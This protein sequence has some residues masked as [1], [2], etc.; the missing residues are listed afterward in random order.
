MLVGPNRGCDEA[1]LEVKHTERLVEAVARGMRTNHLALIIKQARET[2][3]V[4]FKGMI[5]PIAALSWLVAIEEI[6]E[7]G[8]WFP[9]EDNFRI[10]GFLL[11][12]DAHTW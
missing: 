4:A 2:G 3:M 6:F 5:G 8:V 12:G 11:E 7:E 9:N 1:S 10:T